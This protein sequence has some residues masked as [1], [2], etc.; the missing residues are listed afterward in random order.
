VG[1]KS[2]SD[3]VVRFRRGV[4]QGRDVL[5]PGCQVLLLRLSDDMNQNAIV[6]IPRSTLVDEFGCAPPR[7]TEWINHA[8]TAGYLS[9]VRRG[10]PGVTA[11]YQGLVIKPEVREGVPSQRYASADH[12]V[13]REGVPQIE[14]QRYARAV[15][16]EVVA[17]GT[18]VCG[19]S[20]DVG[21]YQEQ[22]VGSSWRAAIGSVS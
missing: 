7:I 10:R 1:A 15:P 6:S 20:R 11:V 9:R 14:G 12:D 2:Y 19:S 13:V 22:G 5:T 16:Q 3:R 4:Y 18:D 21:N 8:V 17:T